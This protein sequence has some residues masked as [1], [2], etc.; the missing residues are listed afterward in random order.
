MI[1][2]F[3][4]IL[5][6][7]LF[8]YCFCHKQDYINV[9]EIIKKQ[10]TSVLIVPKEERNL[11]DIISFI[12]IY[13]VPLILAVLIARAEIITKAFYS[14][15][16]LILAIL[17]SVFLTLISILAAKNYKEKTNKQKRIIKLTYTNVY[18]LT[19]LSILLIII[20]FIKTS[21]SAISI[22]IPSIISKIISNKLI[23]YIINTILV[24][25]LIIYLIIEIIIHLLIVLKRIEQIFIITFND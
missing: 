8:I 6:L 17:V 23:Y 20:C 21:I 16:I 10:I 22:N 14:N 3:I 7:Y 15:I 1:N 25:T 19:V 2:F 4:L 13:I 18:F 9:S 12:N 11:R 24:D 5:S